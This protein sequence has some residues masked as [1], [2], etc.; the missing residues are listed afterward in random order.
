MICAEHCRIPC[1][2][3]YCQSG[4]PS[5]CQAL[6]GMVF[7]SSSRDL[8]QTLLCALPPKTCC[9][10][11]QHKHLLPRGILGSAPSSLPSAAWH[12]QEQ[13]FKF[14]ITPAQERSYDQT[15][16]MGLLLNLGV[17]RSPLHL[18]SSHQLLKQHQNASKRQHCTFFAKQKDILQATCER[19]CFQSHKA[20]KITPR[21][22]TGSGA[23]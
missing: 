2:W 11:A 15:D 16:L 19:Q 5:W 23:K 7:R 17:R 6:Q 1:L 18:W 22:R 13:V 12:G 20:Q 21:R 10:S 9:P 8:Q 3:S 4:H 14:A